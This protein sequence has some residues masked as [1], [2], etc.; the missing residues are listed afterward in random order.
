[1]IYHLLISSILVLHCISMTAMGQAIA[2]GKK[3][4]TLARESYE[5]AKEHVN[6]K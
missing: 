5:A 2:D 3:L 1:M 4:A 6:F